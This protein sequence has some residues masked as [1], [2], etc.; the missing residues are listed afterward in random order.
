MSLGWEGTH[1]SLCRWPM[2]KE[3]EWMP[4]FA[5]V[6]TRTSV[7]A[8]HPDHRKAVPP[9]EQVE[10]LQ[11]IGTARRHRDGFIINLVSV[12]L[13]GTLFVRPPK[14]GEHEESAHWEAHP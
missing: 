3:A 11:R 5:M 7:H 14:T 8:A 4:V 2:D 10:R 1:I 9:S 12:P 13:N 6:G